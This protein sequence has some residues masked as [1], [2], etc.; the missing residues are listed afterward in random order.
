MA[1]PIVSAISYV[2]SSLAELK[3]VTWPGRSVVI[4][5]TIIV[6]IAVGIAAALVALVDAG[7]SAGLKLLLSRGQ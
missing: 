3:K 7:L 4:R 1:N 2:K 5:H 6:V